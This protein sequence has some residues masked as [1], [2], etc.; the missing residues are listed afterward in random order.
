MDES[1]LQQETEQIPQDQQIGA[2]PDD[3]QPDQNGTEDQVPEG[4]KLLIGNIPY[5]T[6]EN[7]IIDLFQK[8]GEI[9]TVKIPRRRGKSKGLAI[10]TTKT[11]EEATAMKN[12]LDGTDITD[13]TGKTRKM[14][15]SF[16]SD[17]PPPSKTPRTQDYRTD[18]RPSPGLAPRDQYYQS[19]RYED[20]YRRDDYRRDDYR[21][22]YYRREDYRRDDYRRDDYRRDDYR[23]D[24]YRRDDYRR[25]ETEDDYSR[26]RRRYDDSDED[27]YR[28]RRERREYEDDYSRRR[29]EDYDYDSMM[30]RP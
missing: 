17:T 25:Q 10:L 26:R 1:P 4:C 12:N 30:R 2:V 16:G 22:D 15:I 29:R 11:P 28:R 24:D 6:T 3:Q 19:R 13:S 21:R 14:Y 9:V 20:E 5:N 23:R 18:R 7:D 8:Y 27:D